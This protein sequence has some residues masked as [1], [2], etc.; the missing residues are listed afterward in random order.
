[1]K[2]VNLQC[3]FQTDGYKKTEYTN[4][5]HYCVRTTISQI[6]SCK[7]GITLLFNL[8]RRWKEFP[9]SN[10]KIIKKSQQQAPKKLIIATLNHNLLF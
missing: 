1:M 10:C 9:Q 8:Y 3:L 2:S 6:F 5:S 4:S 7:I